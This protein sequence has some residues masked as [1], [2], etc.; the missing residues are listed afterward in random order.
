MPSPWPETPFRLITETGV[1]TRP[2]IPQDH[3]CRTNAQTM[4]LTHNS[5]FR[6]LNAIYNQALQVRP[7]SD[8]AADLLLYCIMVYDF[9]HNH[10]QMEEAVYFPGIK[11][12]AGRPRLMSS[13]VE[14]HRDLEK[15]LQKLRK[16]A[17]ETTKEAY[18]A[19]E[20]RGIIDELGEPLGVHLR[21][22]IP[23]ILDL[24]DKVGSKEL[25]AAY[26]DMEKEA[27]KAD[28]HK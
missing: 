2:E 4:A 25:Q 14:Q 22:E 1:K 20:L 10:H 26:L 21:D 28:A 16:Y 9:I 3:Y 5:M 17:E 8:D 11:N 15:G 24:H 7:G 19:N 23:T 18:D 13:N 27:R 12:A 6:G